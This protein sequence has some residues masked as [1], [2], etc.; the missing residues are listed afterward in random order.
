MGLKYANYTNFEVT[1][2]LIGVAAFIIQ[3]VE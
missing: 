2:V 1:V 3:H